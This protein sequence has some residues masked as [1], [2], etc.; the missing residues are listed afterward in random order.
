MEVARLVLNLRFPFVLHSTLINF[1]SS[2]SV[3]V[4]TNLR[5]SLFD[6]RSGSGPSVYM[7]RCLLRRVYLGWKERLTVFL[8][9]VTL[10]KASLLGGGPDAAALAYYLSFPLLVVGA[11][12]SSCSFGASGCG[13]WLCCG[14]GGGLSVSFSAAE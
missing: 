14:W 10:V 3:R 1:R 12:F 4:L 8:L 9:L 5:M 2:R 7:I 13:G 11:C 6:T